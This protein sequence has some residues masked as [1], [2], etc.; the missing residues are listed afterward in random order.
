MT[1]VFRVICSKLAYSNANMDDSRHRKA[2]FSFSLTTWFLA[3]TVFVLL[4]VLWIQ[5][6]QRVSALRDA[7]RFKRRLYEVSTLPITYDRL[8]LIRVSGDVY[9]VKCLRPTTGALDEVCVEWFKISEEKIQQLETE[10]G[11]K[12]TLDQI[13]DDS[14]GQDTANETVGGV[15]SFGPIALR[16]SR[17]G[18]EFGWL[19]LSEANFPGSGMTPVEFDVYR[20]QPTDI[21]YIKSL[22]DWLWQPVAVD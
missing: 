3:T 6:S 9:I 18:P 16:W 5:N 14:K 21:E 22:H 19:Y 7:D 17:G 11:W 10:G 13:P 8:L 4:L 12:Q 20:E 2:K 1:R 15:I